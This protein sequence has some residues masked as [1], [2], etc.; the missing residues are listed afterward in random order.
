METEKPFEILV[1]KLRE[2]KI[3]KLIPIKSIVCDLGCGFH[4]KFIHNLSKRIKNGVGVD[5]KVKQ[6]S[7]G[8]LTF[9]KGNLEKKLN[10]PSNKFE[11]V[12]LLAVLEHLNKPEN[13]VKEAYRILKNGGLLIVTTPSKLS[14]PLLEFLSFKLGLIGVKHIKEHKHYFSK[15]ELVI[16][17]KAVG[18]KEVKVSSFEF[19]MNNLTLAKKIK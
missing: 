14:K 8:N 1:R 7:F 3:L 17:L 6:R 4:G 13:A 10:L 12:T 2:R 15:E 18:F 16:L 11:V 19:G 9:T 5:W